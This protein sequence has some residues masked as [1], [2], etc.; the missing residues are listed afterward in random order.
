M[1]S[2]FDYEFS[3]KVKKVSKLICEE[4][5]PAYIRKHKI[6]KGMLLGKILQDDFPKPINSW[7]DRKIGVRSEYIGKRTILP[8]FFSKLSARRVC[9]KFPVVILKDE[10]DPA[11]LNG[12]GINIPSNLGYNNLMNAEKR[13]NVA[14]LYKSPEG[15]S[16]SFPISQINLNPKDFVGYAGRA[17]ELKIFEKIMGFFANYY[18]S[19]YPETEYQKITLESAFNKDAIYYGKVVGIT[20][21]FTI[22][23][24][25]L[26]LVV[27]LN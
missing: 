20:V 23:A 1:G 18:L 21:L 13:F 14:D 3:Q 27:V 6:G 2:D 9:K 24:T 22:I 11:G 16:Y 15:F 17:L 5:L 10:N 4:V 25:V 26:S 7:V 8:K 12:L 19:R